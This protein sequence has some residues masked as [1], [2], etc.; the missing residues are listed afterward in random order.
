MAYVDRKGR[1]LVSIGIVSC[2]GPL[3]FLYM[4]PIRGQA[5]T[6]LLALSGLSTIFAWCSICYAHIQ[7]RKA[8]PHQGNDVAD[9]IYRSPSGVIGSYIGLTFLILILLAQF[10]VTIA[11]EGDIATTA[12]GK[13][14]NIFEAYSAMPVVLIFYVAYKF[15]FR[16]R[17]V[18]TKDVDLVTGRNEFETPAVRKGWVE[19]RGEWPRWKVLYKTLC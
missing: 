5:F 1:P 19:D 8:W 13:V 14:V 12:K 9:L 6:W 18:R 16:T 17:W 7:F 11:P 4:S 3:A 15:W 10:W 2:A